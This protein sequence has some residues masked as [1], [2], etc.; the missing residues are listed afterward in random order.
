MFFSA[1]SELSDQSKIAIIIATTIVILLV[2][3]LWTA[4]TML[5]LVRFSKSRSQKLVDLAEYSEDDEGDEKR[6]LLQ[7]QEETDKIGSH[8]CT[9][10]FTATYYNFNLALTEKT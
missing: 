2:L 5:Y 9:V 4:G 10:Q 8:L 3:I 1:G 7:P 6:P